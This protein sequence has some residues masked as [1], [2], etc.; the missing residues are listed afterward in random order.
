MIEIRSNGKT[1]YVSTVAIAS[2]TEAGASS[3]WHGVR[4]YIKTFDGMTIDCEQT[5]K[6]V[7]EA[8]KGQTP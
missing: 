7:I 8:M 6:E 5:A 2:V 4:S 3:Q 1:V